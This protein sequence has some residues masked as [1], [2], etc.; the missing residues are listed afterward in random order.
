MK[1]EVSQFGQKVFDVDIP[2]EDL[3]N[4]GD[5]YYIDF[6]QDQ[7]HLGGSSFAQSLDRIGKETPSVQDARY[8]KKA[9][10]AVQDHISNRKINAGHDIGSGGLI[11]TLLELCF[12]SNSVGM[13]IDF[14]GLEETDL[15][16]ILFSEKVGVVLQSKENLTASFNKAP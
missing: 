1:L 8:F 5:I 15:V 6:A 7:F 11:T 10:N 12:A 2:K 4:G 16:K 9:F 3:F 13:N 14:S